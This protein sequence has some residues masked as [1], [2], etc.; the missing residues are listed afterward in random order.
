[1]TITGRLRRMKPGE[2]ITLPST[3]LAGLKS[4]TLTRL[5]RELIAERADWVVGKQ[6]PMTGEFKVRRITKEA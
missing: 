2:V 4:M 3:A 1:M 5:R 6:D